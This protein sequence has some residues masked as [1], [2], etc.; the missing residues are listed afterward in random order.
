LLPIQII[1]L[2]GI[3]FKIDVSFKQAIYTVGTYSYQFWMAAMKLRPRRSGNQHPHHESTFYRDQLRRK[4]A[5]YHCHIQL[6]VIAQGLLQCR[7]VLEPRLVWSQFGSWLR[8][9]RPGL[10]PSE[11]V[12]AVALR[13]S[14][15]LF[16]SDSRKNNPLAKFIRRILDLDRAEGL[17][18]VA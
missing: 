9:I 12:V 17:E 16:L 15:P 4:L 5:A 6:G 3:R 11:Q 7:A 18:S 8:T 13:H 14:L 10:L 1:Q 2:Y